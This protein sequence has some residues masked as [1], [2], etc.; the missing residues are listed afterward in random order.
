M[1]KPTVYY[2]S[3]PSHSM[4]GMHYGALRAVWLTPTTRQ[5]RCIPGLSFNS[6][7]THSFSDHLCE[8]IN[9]RD[10][11]GVTDWAMLHADIE[12]QAGW[13]D[14]LADERAASKADIISAVVPQK[15]YV[16]E[17]GATSTGVGKRLPNGRPECLRLSMHDVYSLP[18]TFDI[19]DTPWPEQALL[20]NTGCMLMSVEIA[21]MFADAGG[22]AF[23]NWIE[24]E[25]GRRVAK[26]LSEDWKLSL[27]AHEQ[28]LKVAATRKVH[29]NHWGIK[30]FGNAAPWGDPRHN[31]ILPQEAVA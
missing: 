13:V 15:P 26:C 1:G 24:I 6:V 28:G 18:E 30:A 5:I 4:F 3:I 16:G 8:A 25:D 19:T 20:I 27:W 9:E 23:E 14:I 12:A 7:L 11:H 17:G 31:Q 2:V 22:F 10:E 29:L 21:E